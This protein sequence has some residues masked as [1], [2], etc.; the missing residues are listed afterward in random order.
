[1]GQLLD[2]HSARGLLAP[3]LRPLAASFAGTVVV[4]GALVAGCGNDCTKFGPST[5]GLELPPELGWVLEEY[6]IDDECLSAE[7]RE[8]EYSYAINVRDRPDTYHYLVKLTA[9]DGRSVVSEGEVET[10]A[11]RFDDQTCKPTTFF[12]RLIVGPNGGV[13]T[14]RDT[15]DYEFE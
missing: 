2:S 10:W 15:Y 6:C 7:Q 4:A 3:C 13:R 9:S 14:Q 12:G 5:V 11:P 1:M 8:F